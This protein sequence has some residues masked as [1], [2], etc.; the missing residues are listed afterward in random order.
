MMV[1]VADM[2]AFTASTLGGLTADRLKREGL[3]F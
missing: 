2:H 3:Q 1:G